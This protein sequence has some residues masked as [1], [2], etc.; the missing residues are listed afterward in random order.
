MNDHTRSYLM[1]FFIGLSVLCCATSTAN[2]QISTNQ[3]SHDPSSQ[4]ENNQTATNAASEQPIPANPHNPQNGTLLQSITPSESEL[5][6]ANTQL[7]AQNAKLTREV[8]T[9]TTQV[10]I[11]VQEQSGQLFAYGGVTAI[12]SVIIGFLLG[13]LTNRQRW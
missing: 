4:S 11:L 1:V 5:S 10:N 8:E 7:L 9:L 12:V 2:Q 3:I 13:K 6:Y